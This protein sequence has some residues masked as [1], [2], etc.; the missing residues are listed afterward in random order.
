MD[1]RFVGVDITRSMIEV[2]VRPTGELWTSN[3]NDDG[4]A[5]TADKLRYLRP[6][7]VVME[8][9]GT[10]ELAVA[11][12]LATEGLPFALVHPRTVRDFA[13]AIGRMARADKGQA[14]LLAYFAELV[15]PEVRTLPTEVVLQLKDLRNRRH[16]IGQ[17][18]LL[19]KGRLAEGPPVVQKDLQA[20]IQY[21]EKS[22]IT[23]DDQVNKTIRSSTVWR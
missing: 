15:R 19:E 2:A 10:Y 6:E 11:G 21:L 1:G 8:A 9:N 22:L 5:E 7:L 18:I 12:T 4:M 13:R 16:D 23:I 14:G 20:H 3:A 17:M